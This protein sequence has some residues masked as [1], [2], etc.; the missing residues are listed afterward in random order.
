MRMR[1]INVI[2][3]AQGG[4]PVEAHTRMCR[5][6]RTRQ[7]THLNELKPTMLGSSVH[8]VVARTVTAPRV[9]IA[10]HYYSTVKTR[11]ALL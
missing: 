2:A 1:V 6:P 3:Q 11:M 10:F 4:S 9:Y 5:D 7:V 8:A